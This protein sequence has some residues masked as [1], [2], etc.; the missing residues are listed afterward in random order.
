MGA[1]ASSSSQDSVSPGLDSSDYR[2]FGDAGSCRSPR[3][4]GSS[5]TSSSSQA[6]TTN[7]GAT[8]NGPSGSNGS[9]KRYFTNSR[10][11]WRQQNVNGAF[12]ELR[13]LVPTYPPDKKLSKNEILRLAIKYIRLLSNVLEFQKRQDDDEEEEEGEEESGGEG[14]DVKPNKDVCQKATE[15]ALESCLIS[16]NSMMSVF[17]SLTGGS[18]GG[19]LPSDSYLHR[20]TSKGESPFSLPYHNQTTHHSQR[21]ASKRPLSNGIASS[22]PSAPSSLS[23]SYG[24]HSSSMTTTTTTAYGCLPFPVHNSL[25]PLKLEIPNTTTTTNGNCRPPAKKAKTLLTCL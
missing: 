5:S 6:T 10:E 4:T 17:Q 22:S 25:S 2:L 9:H 7:N 1:P 11:R 8:E 19:D 23:L 21:A 12:N 16:P 18:G 20:S 13:R 24:L 15:S 3:S 14:D